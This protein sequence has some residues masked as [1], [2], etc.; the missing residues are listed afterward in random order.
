M[1]LKKV[2]K[3]HIFAIISILFSVVFFLAVLEIY[4]RIFTLPMVTP[5]YLMTHPTRRYELKPNFIGKT[6]SADVKI[7]SMGLRDYERLVDVNAY[8]I[9]IFG[10]SITFGVGVNADKTF[11]KVL[12]AKLNQCFGR[13]KSLQVFNCGILSYNTITEYRYMVDLYDKLKPQMIIIEYTVQNDSMLSADYASDM[14]TN[15]AVRLFKDILRQLYI[16]DFFSGRFYEIIYKLQSG[17]QGNPYKSLVDHVAPNYD[18]AYSGW[19]ETQKAFKDI[20]NFA[21][22]KGVKVIFAI[23]ANNFQLSKKAQDDLMYPVVTKIERALRD[24]GIDSIILL[25]DGFRM[26]SG[27]ER[28]LWV[29]DFD[30]EHFSELAHLLAAELLF[31][32]F[33]TNNYCKF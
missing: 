4:L 6:Y 8:R 21:D 29:K 3:F 33:T 25:D 15:K 20:K 17:R 26:F 23:F 30:D 32:F 11:V 1:K 22:T 9:A 16:Y 31:N 24:A 2:I 7:N 28:L 12:E 19:I 14:N 18:D 10:D 13:K 5:G 27:N